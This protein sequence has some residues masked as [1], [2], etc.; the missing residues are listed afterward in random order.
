MGF[1]VSASVHVLLSKVFPP[2]GL[3][4]VD[5][6]DV[7]GTFNEKIDGDGYLEDTASDEASEKEKVSV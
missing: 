3:G 2:V 1:V 6:E 4:E 5:D 7:Y